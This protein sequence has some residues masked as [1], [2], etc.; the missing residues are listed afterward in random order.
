MEGLNINA[1]KGDF[2]YNIPYN[3]I[4]RLKKAYGRM[5]VISKQ[6]YEQRN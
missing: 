4:S 6:R 5:L 2:W 3:N 1:L